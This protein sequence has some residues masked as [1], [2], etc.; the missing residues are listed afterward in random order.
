M[1]TTTQPTADDLRAS[2]LAA[3]ADA[4]HP[5]TLDARRGR[6]TFTA[7]GASVA[8]E[9]G[10]AYGRETPA[11]IVFARFSR[12]SSR[13][14]PRSGRFNWPLVAQ[15]AREIADAWRAEGERE[16]E[17]RLAQAMAAQRADAVNAS[18][19]LARDAAVRAG[20]EGGRLVFLVQRREVSEEQ[21]RVMVAAARAC[22]L[23]DGAV[24]AAKGEK[25]T[26]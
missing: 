21:I 24:A 8:V 9:I 1:T 20:A 19:G 13:F 22:G 23:V 11:S 7:D 25:E 15:T 26:V 10:A 14:C 6:L 2:L 5:A 18:L 16:N 3:C 17:Q 4:G 12:H